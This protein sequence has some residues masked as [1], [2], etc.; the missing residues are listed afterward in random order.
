M[1]EKGISKR[2]KTLE[3][4]LEW[5]RMSPKARHAKS[6]ARLSAYESLMNEDVKEREQKLEIFIPNGPRLGDFVIDAKGVAKAF[7]DKLLFKD[8]EFSLPPNGIVSNWPQ[9]SRKT[10]LFRMIMNMESADKGEFNV[11]ETVV[12]GYADQ[13][14]LLSI[15]K[16]SI[17]GSFGW[18][19]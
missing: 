6:K 11:G 16:N 17:S 4:E 13:T 2:R 10:T 9:W 7:G 8:L 3:R 19:G 15:L 5:V 14:I 18:T 1:E 12:I